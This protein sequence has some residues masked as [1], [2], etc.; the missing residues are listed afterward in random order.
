MDTD[1]LSRGDPLAAEVSL[2]I[3]N[4]APALTEGHIQD[5]S[6]RDNVQEPEPHRFDDKQPA[7]R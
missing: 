3:L 5:L 2:M 1:V 7:I 4:V 6:V